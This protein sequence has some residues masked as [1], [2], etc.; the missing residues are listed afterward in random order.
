[1]G[2]KKAS[3]SSGVAETSDISTQN[4]RPVWAAISDR[5]TD[6]FSIARARSQATPQLFTLCYKLARSVT[7]LYKALFA[8]LD[9]KQGWLVKRLI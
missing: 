7:F 9:L 2:V 4:I 3:P 1:M 5:L 8:Y 6:S